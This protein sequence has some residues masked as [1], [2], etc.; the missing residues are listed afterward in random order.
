M[1]AK[2][3]LI[4]AA[5]TGVFLLFIIAWNKPVRNLPEVVYKYSTLVK[6]ERNFSYRDLN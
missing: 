6:T 5:A 2:K 3:I 4:A 1:P